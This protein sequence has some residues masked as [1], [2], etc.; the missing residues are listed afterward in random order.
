MK[1]DGFQ[2]AIGIAAC[3]AVGLAQEAS[4]KVDIVRVTGCLR[5]E[6]AEQW[7]LSAATDPLV[8]PRGTQPVQPPQQPPPSTAGTN[9]Y[10]LIGV[11]EFDL[12]S[13]KD[14]LVSVKGLLIK[15]TPMSRLNI[16]SVTTLADACAARK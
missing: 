14:H 2:A 6:S 9:Q 16:T 1:A 11:E 5:H 12:P 8:V 13:R 7:V 15:A 3:A 4:S 10:R